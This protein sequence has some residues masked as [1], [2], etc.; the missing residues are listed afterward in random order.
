ME[1]FKTLILLVIGLIAGF[2]MGI[3]GTA[4]MMNCYLPPTSGAQWDTTMVAKTDTFNISHP[5]AEKEI[6]V[7]SETHR[8]PLIHQGNGSGGPALSQA[9]ADTTYEALNIRKYGAGAGGEPRQCRDSVAVEI[10]ITQK[11]YRD[12]TYE[13]WVSGYSQRLDSIRVYARTETIRVRDYKPPDRWHLGITAGWAMTPRGMQPYA[14]IGIT[15]SII[16]WK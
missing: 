14:G 16:S 15:Y 13:A 1:H 7:E 10:P 12:S 9:S 5:T 11:H 2:V 8:L 4:H 6:V 3:V